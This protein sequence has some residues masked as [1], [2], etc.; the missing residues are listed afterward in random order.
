MDRR[1][2]IAALAGALFAI[3]VVYRLI[4]RLVIGD[5]TS[6]DVAAQDRLSWVGWA[7]VVLVTAVV[8]AVGIHRRHTGVVAADVL[9]SV[10]TAA[11]LVVLVGPFV[12]A[13]P[14]FEGGI[15]MVIIELVVFVG[16]VGGGALVGALAMI[17]LGRD[18]RSRELR[19]F[20]QARLSRPA[21]RPAHR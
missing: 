5:E 7:T 15:S 18:R 6:A 14:R 8:T 11:L 17:A 16:I 3:N 20:A 13:P 1:W 12:S 21:R 9:A 4:G 2:R 19:N 10:G